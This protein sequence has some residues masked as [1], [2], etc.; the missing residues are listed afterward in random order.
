MPSLWRRWALS[1]KARRGEAAAVAGRTRQ[2]RQLLAKILASDVGEQLSSFTILP[3][4]QLGLALAM[5]TAAES[6]RAV[7]FAVRL[8]MA[9]DNAGI[10]PGTFLISVNGQRTAGLD[11]AS[12]NDLIAI[13]FEAN[14]PI[15]LE[16]AEPVG[17][18][19][20]LA[21]VPIRGSAVEMDIKTSEV[22]YGA[23]AHCAKIPSTN[24]W[25]RVSHTIINASCSS[26][27]CASQTCSSHCS[28]HL[29][30]RQMQLDVVEEPLLAPSQLLSISTIS[31]REEA[32][33]L[34]SYRFCDPTISIGIGIAL[35]ARDRAIIYAVHAGSVS[36]RLGIQ[37]PCFLV[38]VNGRPTEGLGLKAIRKLCV[39]AQ[40]DEAVRLDI[41]PM[42][43]AG[44]APIARP[45]E[46]SATPHDE[47]GRLKPKSGGVRRH[48]VVVPRRQPGQPKAKTVAVAKVVRK[49]AAAS[50]T[51]TVCA[52]VA[53]AGSIFSQPES[54]HNIEPTPSR[55]IRE[56]SMLTPPR[57]GKQPESEAEV[58]TASSTR[59]VTPTSGLSNRL[60]VRVSAVPLPSES[61]GRRA[62]SSQERQ[63]CLSPSFPK[64]VV[65]PT[66]GDMHAEWR[67]GLTFYDQSPNNGPVD[68]KLGLGITT[69]GGI[70]DGAVALK[71]LGCGVQLG[72]KVG[73]SVFDNEVSFDFRRLLLCGGRGPPRPVRTKG[74]DQHLDRDQ[75]SEAT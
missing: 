26:Q 43:A 47:Y 29:T 1:S 35:D 16:T 14:A 62:A 46:Q 66:P 54:A 48:I 23:H 20:A 33:P 70:K 21:M 51:M 72:S 7:V 11:L 68:L 41:R 59:T 39:T 69:G 19:S 36:A 37:A 53:G 73:V 34:Q 56:T 28:S 38:A 52:R 22:Q 15:T 75:P 71:A 42:A 27:K 65:S 6:G 18:Q 13:A 17:K 50:D 74:T 60:P 2:Q 3:G 55:E 10:E 32:D 31:S 61:V 9:A 57:R 45:C 8:G 5:D 49:V 63:P 24:I 44:A 30:S 64:T 58:S 4:R 25:Q 67:A 40:S 12:V